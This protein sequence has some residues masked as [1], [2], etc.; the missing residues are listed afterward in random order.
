MSI[1]VKIPFFRDRI[2]QNTFK[3]LYYRNK[4]YLLPVFIFMVATILT[5]FAVIPQIRDYFV[6][7]NE[8]ENIAEKIKII[9]NNTAVLAGLNEQEL[10]RKLQAATLALPVEKDF[11]GIL[12]A[13]GQAAIDANVTLGDFSFQLGSLTIGATKITNALPI[14]IAL[15]VNDN[16]L[17]TKRFLRELSRRL[18]LSEVT[19]L[20]VNE[21]STNMT[22]IFYY[23][24]IS[25]LIFNPSEKIKVI[26]QKESSLLEE[27]L[28]SSQ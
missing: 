5:F 10:N 12:R 20:R 9:N 13:I 15:T 28:P 16:V 19:N 6:L 8:E 21:S 17:G 27:L 26:S 11:G 25:R 2:D 22:V 1:N 18:P 3:I 24:P 4:T 7:K 23:K 14:E